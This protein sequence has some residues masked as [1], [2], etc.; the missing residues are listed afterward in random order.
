M[1]DKKMKELFVDT[2][3]FAR[4]LLQDVPRQ[5]EAAKKIFESADKRETKLLVSI[6]VINELIW[7]LEKYYLLK[8]KDFIHPLLTLLALNNLKVVEVKKEMVFEVLEKMKSKRVDFTYL[9]L[10][11]VAGSKNIFS[12]DKD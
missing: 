8:R 2:N 12:F 9:Y 5:F 10:L 1:D 3:V 6:L 11:S 7:V 4:F